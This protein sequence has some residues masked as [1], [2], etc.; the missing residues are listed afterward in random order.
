MDMLMPGVGDALLVVDV[1]NDFLPGGALGVPHGDRVLA[2]INNAI[3]LFLARGLPIFASRDWHPANHCS[4]REQGGP[5]PPHCV[6][7][8]PGA[9]FS[10]VL[11]LPANATLIYKATRVDEE[12]YSV[13][14][15]TGFEGM[16]R[17][18]A[19][20]RIFIGGLATDYCVLATT[21]DACL[22]GFSVVVLADAVSAVDVH[23][24]DGERALA[25]MRQ[26]CAQ[27]TT[28]ADLQP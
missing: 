23:P 2:P 26:L 14:G 10:S 5:W 27:L 22:L 4:F 17:R 20:R 12:A 24:G 13:F 7:D 8:T 9:A 28:S 21:R 11:N 1:Q 3:A 15:G 18:A 19:V 6:A 16:L 25:E